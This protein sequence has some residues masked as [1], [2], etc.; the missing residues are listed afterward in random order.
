M[1]ETK[2]IVITG[3]SGF[4]GGHVAKYFAGKGERITCLLR[5]GSD[6]GFIDDLPV[7]KTMGDILE[8]ES[9]EQAFMGMDFVI[10]VAARVGD[11][12]KYEDFY[13]TNVQGTLNVLEA[14]L[15]NNI[16]NVMITGSVSSYGEEDCRSP[17]NETSPYRSHYPYF[18]DKMFP[19]AMNYYRD[20]KA[21]M[22]SESIAFAQ[23]NNMNLTIIEPVWVYGENEFTSGFYEYLKSVS[24]GL[25]VM[26]GSKK[27]LFHVVY[28]GDL[29]EAY[30]AA[31]KKNLQG[32][33]RII[34]GNEKPEL[35]HEI[36]KTYC[37]EANLKFPRLLPKWMVYPF[38]FVIEMIFTALKKK[39]APILTRS[40]VNM[41]YDSIA[42]K[43]DNALQLLSFRCKTD[44]ETGINK[45]VSW[46]IQHKYL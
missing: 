3:A 37:R 6:T 44:T 45:T 18:M 32:I 16:R 29:A 8:I 28:A 17:K 21:L 38:G 35:M 5:P 23:K 42:Y 9:L 39:S 25:P 1:S 34:I 20:T 7:N 11:W 24:S 30:Y 26:P 10:H 46:Y 43:T 33:H 4:I 2:N 12:G 14:A 22:T 13:K 40:R 15:H 19:S 31:Y 36:Y 41:F 27:N